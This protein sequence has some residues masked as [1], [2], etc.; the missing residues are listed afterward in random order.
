MPSFVVT[1]LTDRAFEHL[2]DC[3]VISD[4]SAL[5][6]SHGISTRCRRHLCSSS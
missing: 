1:I 2:I 3:D 5:Q 4:V 6:Y